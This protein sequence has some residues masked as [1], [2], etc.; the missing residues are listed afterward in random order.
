ML[1][2]KTA[3]CTHIMLYQ[4]IG[5][6]KYDITSSGASQRRIRYSAA[7]WISEIHVLYHSPC[8]G[9]V[10]L[11]AAHRLQPFG[12]GELLHWNRSL[13]IDTAP[14]DADDLDTLSRPS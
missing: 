11:Q 5:Q 1:L 6:A 8:D 12:T 14:S 2:R 10:Q 3:S 13:G 4:N 9:W 7:E